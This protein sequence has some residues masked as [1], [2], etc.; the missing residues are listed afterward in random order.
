MFALGD[1]GRIGELVTGAGFGQPELEEITFEFRYE[2][3]ADLWDT[4]LRL[5]G[6]LAHAINALSDDER[7]ATR[8]AIEESMSPYR[9]EDGSYTPSAVTW[10]VLAR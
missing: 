9:N 6:P 7:Q 8:A 5:T 3:F 2:D 10:G 4:L 1:P